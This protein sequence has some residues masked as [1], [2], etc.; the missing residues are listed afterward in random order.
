MAMSD[1]P[2]EVRLESM[3]TEVGAPQVTNQLN[4]HELTAT[5]ANF[6][7][8][9]GTPE[10]WVVEFGL[11]IS[12]ADAEQGP[13]ELTPRVVMNFFTAKRLFYALGAALERHESTFGVI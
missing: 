6:C 13:I 2:S 12:P 11:N 4:E 10:E 5:Y 1:T 8:V 7:R 3:A 9:T